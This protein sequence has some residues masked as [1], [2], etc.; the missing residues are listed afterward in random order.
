[1]SRRPV[2]QQEI[3]NIKWNQP[4]CSKTVVK[5]SHSGRVDK[6]YAKA[7]MSGALMSQAQSSMPPLSR[8]EQCS[9]KRRKERREGG[10]R[11]YFRHQWNIRVVGASPPGPSPLYFNSWLRH[12]GRSHWSKLRSDIPEHTFLNRSNIGEQG[13]TGFTGDSALM[14]LQELPFISNKYGR[15]T[16]NRIRTGMYGFFKE[17]SCKIMFAFWYATW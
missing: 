4:C 11:H 3:F 14:L 10:N 15:C 8:A 13:T 5:N 2:F 7:L 12:Q 17:K 9:G 6:G 1:M 16:S